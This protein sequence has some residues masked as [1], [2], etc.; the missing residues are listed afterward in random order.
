M[1][2][3]RSLSLCCLAKIVH[4]FVS[5]YYNLSTL[6]GIIFLRKMLYKR[7]NAFNVVKSNFCYVFCS[8]KYIPSSIIKI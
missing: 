7:K 6:Q 8:P 2:N 3:Y 4:R 5:G 1:I